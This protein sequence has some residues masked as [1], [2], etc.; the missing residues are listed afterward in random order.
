MTA[1]LAL[2]F[3]IIAALYAA[4]GNGGGTGYLA[5]MSLAGLPPDV[6][7]PTA[8]ALNIL[9]AGIGTWKYVRAGHFSARLFWPVAAVSIPFA[10]LGG[11]LNLAWT[12]YR[13]ALGVVLLLAALRLWSSTREPADAA[14]RVDLPLWV[15]LVVGIGVGFLSGLLGIG[16]GIL[17]GP[18]LLL[19]GWTGTREALGVTAAFVLVN[20]AAG[21]LGYL[22]GVPALP[23]GIWLWLAAAGA[24]GWIGA[25]FG[26]RR[27]NPLVLRRLL[28]VLLVLAGLRMLVG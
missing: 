22:S 12:L 7:K 6:M 9:V 25:E 3:F 19:A 8:L 27:L 24:G 14:R 5:V 28:A 15:A 18:L 23:P 21:L 16:G 11:R 4:V 26:S 1:I 13:P 20:S 17:L 2:L 10:F